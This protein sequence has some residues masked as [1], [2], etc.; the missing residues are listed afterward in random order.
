M[1]KTGLLR[2]SSS[3]S[4]CHHRGARRDQ[5]GHHPNSSSHRL[6]YN[7]SQPISRH[8]IRS[9]QVASSGYDRS[10]RVQRQLLLQRPRSPRYHH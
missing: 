4:Q 2:L 8:P 9:Y 10:C 7:H 5:Q 6:R 3:N 1:Y